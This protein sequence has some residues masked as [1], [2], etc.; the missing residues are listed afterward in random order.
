MNRRTI[1][2]VL[3]T[4]VRW[5]SNK[6]LPLKQLEKTTPSKPEWAK[7]DQTLKQR[8]G[9][10]NPTRKLTRQQMQDVR[11]FQEQLPHLKTVELAQYFSISPEAIRRILKSS[12]TPKESE[13]DDIMKRDEKRK[14][15]NRA[16]NQKLEQDL[17]HAHERLNYGKS[18]TFKEVVSKERSETN[19]TNYKR[20]YNSAKMK[21]KRGNKE[22]VK[23]FV[24]GVGHMID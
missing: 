19:G 8:Y 12:W 23:P 4:P 24:T 22:Q 9:G 17:D 21:N 6:T 5:Y 3:N 20:N 1:L 2:S 13:E 18:D 10:W 14:A 11:N 15:R 16:I 7:R